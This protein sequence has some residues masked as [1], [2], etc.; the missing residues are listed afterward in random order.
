MKAAPWIHVV[1][2]QRQT[3]SVHGSLT[4]KMTPCR[5]FLLK[6]HTPKIAKFNRKKLPANNKSISNF[7]R[8]NPD[9]D[10]ALEKNRPLVSLVQNMEHLLPILRE[11]E[12]NWFALVAEL[13]TLLQKPR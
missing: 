9:P 4:M 13:I 7:P 5:A 8:S 1:L 6:I 2:G 12:L 3:L 11:N 10:I